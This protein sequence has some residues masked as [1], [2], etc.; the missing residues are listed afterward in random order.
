MPWPQRRGVES[1]KRAIVF[2]GRRH[3]GYFNRLPGGS[4]PS[5]ST[6]LP[7]PVHQTLTA[8]LLL[9]ALLTGGCSTSDYLAGFLVRPPNGGKA[10]VDPERYRPIIFDAASHHPVTG[11]PPAILAYYLF[12]PAPAR[13]TR[14]A[15]DDASAADPAR[16]ALRAF[17]A[18]QPGDPPRARVTVAPWDGDRWALRIARGRLVPN[19]QPARA[20]VL[21]LQGFGNR[22]ATSDYLWHVAAWLAADGCRVVLADLRAQGDSTGPSVTGGRAEVTDLVQLLNHLQAAGQL[23]GPLGV[24]GHSYGGGI[25][26]QLA[27]HDPRVKRVLALSPLVDLRATLLGGLQHVAKEKRPLAWAAIGWTIR[28]RTVENALIEAG[29]RAGYDPAIHNA[30]AAIPRVHVPIDIHQGD[31]DLATPLS[32]TRRLLAANP[33]HTTLTLYPGATHAAWLRQDLP[34][35]RQRIT[36]WVN[37]LAP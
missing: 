29:R 18:P 26:I 8:T 20:T 15:L 27:A 33:E 1:T 14:H 4:A 19:A 12:E 32:E 5:G 25:A 7:S 23:Q 24:A 34:Q 11:P 35:L 21:L 22:A 37:L 9:A 31:R 28:Q 36:G 16:A 10:F 3:V 6:S 30:L 17:L 2:A 13:V